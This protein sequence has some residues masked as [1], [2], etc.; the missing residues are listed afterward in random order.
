MFKYVNELLGRK[1]TGISDRFIIDGVSITDN[2]IISEKFVKYF[3]SVPV[4]V[5]QDIGNY[6]M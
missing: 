3:E 1:A 4:N 6:G 5:R 2:V